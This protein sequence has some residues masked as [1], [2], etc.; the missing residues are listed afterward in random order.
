MRELRRMPNETARRRAAPAR[1]R[2]GLAVLLTVTLLFSLLAGGSP[3]AAWADDP[4]VPAVAPTTEVFEAAPTHPFLIVKESEYAVLRARANRYPWSGMKKQAGRECAGLSYSSTASIAAKGVR[5]RDI[6]GSCSLMYV[7]DPDERATYRRRMETVLD[8]WPAV[9]EQMER[10]YPKSKNRWSQ[11]VPPSSGFFN[12]VL[13]LDVIHDDLSSTTLARY[14]SSMDSVAE[15]YWAADRGWGTA[16]YGARAVWATYQGDVA[17]RTTAAQQY[18]QQYLAWL[19]P[20]GAFKDGPEY[21]LARNGGERS[22][23][24]GYLYVAE[25]TGVDPTY[26][27]D[28]RVRSFMEWLMGFAFGPFNGMVGFGDS[29]VLGRD[30]NTFKPGTAVFA[31]GRFS[32]Q[33]A[34]SAARHV[35][36]GINTMPGDLLS[37]SVTTAAPVQARGPQSRVWPASG[38]AFWQ[39]SQSTNALMG[40]LWNPSI[41]PS[42]VT[43]HMHRE[44]NALYIAG[45]GEALLLNSGYNGYGKGA[46]GT[47]WSEIHS[48][49]K[50]SNTVVL[51]GANHLTAAGDG[52]T[53]YLTGNGLEYASGVGDKIYPGE[54]AHVRNFIMVQP[55]DKKNGYFL[56][57]DDVHGAP[58]GR[59]VDIYFH[60]AS[61][62]V[63]TVAAGQEYRWAVSRRKSTR[64]YLSVFLGTRPTRTALPKSVIAGWDKSIVARSLDARFVTDAAGGRQV[65]T[66][67]VPHDGTHAKPALKR[68]SGLGYT[69]ARVAQGAFKDYAVAAGGRTVSVGGT[70]LTA[71]S[72]VFRRHGEKTS[73]YF[74]RRG[75]AFD[76]GDGQGVVSDQP[77]SVHMR[78]RSGSVA[79]LVPTVVTFRRPGVRRITV[80]GLP[81]SATAV[82]GGLQLLVLPGH[83][84]IVLS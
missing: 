52:V 76:G 66:V 9:L 11:V 27:A 36:A 34:A 31:A 24:Q 8:A 59:T 2:G 51:G 7:L 38:A 15:W 47:S 21:A 41:T 13:A 33:A 17:R 53:D 22:A 4:T 56:S 35:A 16:T 84:T 6:M 43:A 39:R 71:D 20:D 48:T 40:A 69:G 70:T 46:L 19:T 14:E 10:E 64:T 77:V 5:I 37:Y 81:A 55:Q 74:I 78:G 44:V 23:K 29:G 50:A 75:R 54:A 73:F 1:Q 25:Y 68:L 62:S 82:P 72:A 67:L 32:P 42:Q 18:H 26:Y 80:D 65:V 30:L 28:P 83:H 45:Y 12:S 60:P 79:A 63:K 3:V 57:I 61:A 58:A 49:A